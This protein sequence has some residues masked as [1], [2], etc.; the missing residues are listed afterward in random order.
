MPVIAF[1]VRHHRTA[2]VAFTAQINWSG[3]AMYR[4]QL[5]LAVFWAHENNV[6][7]RGCDLSHAD[8]HCSDLRDCDLRDSN[9]RNCNLR[10]SD[11]S[12]GNL[13]GCDLRNCDLRD[14][15][16]SDCILRQSDLRGSNLSD[17]DLS[18]C[19]LSGCNLH[20]CELSGSDLRDCN[21]TG[22]DLRGC[23]LGSLSIPVIP[24]IHA[25]VYTAASA[26]GALDMS[27]WHACRTTHC[28]AGWVTTLAG[29]SGRELE[30]IYGTSA[31]A[32]LI[33]QASDPKLA[34]IPNFHADGAD[35]LADMKRLAELQLQPV[36]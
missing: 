31:A 8:L 16:L 12:D 19:D 23:S 34:Q 3:L 10:G 2:K 21:L 35:A 27:D 29:N 13:Q 25:A 33:Y 1:D 36:A 7:M 9:L 26:P 17:C 30:H 4:I 14:S 5:G 24:D 18:S 6:D 15:N 11:L 28:R 20:G 32:A 22:C